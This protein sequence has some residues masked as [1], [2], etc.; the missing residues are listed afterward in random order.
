MNQLATAEQVDTAFDARIYALIGV[1][2]FWSKEK[3]FKM[4]QDPVQHMILGFPGGR[5]GAMIF[6][7]GFVTGLEDLAKEVIERGSNVRSELVG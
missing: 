4:E 6:L 7:G 5:G 3:H 1:R 2:W